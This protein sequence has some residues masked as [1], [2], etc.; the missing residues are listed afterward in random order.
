MI[1][2][3][4]DGDDVSKP[5]AQIRGSAIALVFLNLLA[6]SAPAMT[7]KMPVAIVIPPN[8][9]LEDR[10]KYVWFFLRPQQVI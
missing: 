2:R 5:T 4:M 7:P 10:K 1:A 8:I 3:Y 6:A 9:W